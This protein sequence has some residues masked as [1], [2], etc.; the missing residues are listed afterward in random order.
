MQ[1]TIRDIPKKVDSALRANARSQGKS[2]NQAAV[3]AMQIGVGITEHPVKRR[4]L[5]EFA[6]TWIDDP[7]VDAALRDQDRIDPEM[8]K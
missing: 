1:Y 8:W 2:L 5:S 4:D 3:E 6:N 7:E